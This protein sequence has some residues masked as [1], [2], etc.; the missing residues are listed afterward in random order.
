M[1]CGDTGVAHL[2]TAF[3]TPSV[4]I[5]RPVHRPRLWGTPPTDRTSCSGRAAR[6]SPTPT[7]PPGAAGDRCAGRPRRRGTPA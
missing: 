2:A 6:G 4:V 1:I 3:A 7:G 5:V